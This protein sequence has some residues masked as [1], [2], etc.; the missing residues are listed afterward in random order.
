MAFSVQELSDRLEI[1]D[2][3]VRYTQAID[4]KDWN[5]LDTCFTQDADVD[6]TSAGGIAGRYPEVRKWLE[7]ALAPFQTT[8]HYVAN[9]RVEL[10]GDRARSRTAVHNPM[11]FQNPDGSP[12]QF[13]VGAYYV[14]ELVRTP[15]GWRIC[16]RTEEQAFMEGSLPQA[17]QIPGAEG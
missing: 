16:K 5:L 13:N 11:V 9:S 1:N 12:H 17:L 7:M 8:V 6:Y 4:Q 3:L 2:L 10:D 15:E 14:D